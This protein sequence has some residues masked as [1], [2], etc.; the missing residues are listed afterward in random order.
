M[1][2]IGFH[3]LARN[4]LF[5]ARDYYDDLVYG[6]GKLFIWEIERCLNVIKSN[7]LAYPITKENIRKAVILK[8]PYSILYRV[9]NNKI[10]IL[11]VM[12]Q[13]RKPNYWSRRI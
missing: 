7:P 8:F 6:L 13:K 4:E 5:D 1:S 10:Y 12:H 2:S 9:D 3:E 11:A